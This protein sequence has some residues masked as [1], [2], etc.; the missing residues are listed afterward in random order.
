MSIK[1]FRDGEFNSATVEFLTSHGGVSA[2]TRMLIDKD[3]NV[4]IGSLAGILKGTAGVVSGGATHAELASID[5]NQHI[6]HTTVSISAGTGMSGGG[7]IAANRTLTCTITQYTDALARTACIASSI[8]DGDLTHSPDGN[9]VFDALALK[10]PIAS[11]TFTGTVTMPASIV[12]PDGGTIGQAAGPLIAF[13]D[14]LNYL[15]ITG[16]DVGIGTITPGAKLD[17]AGSGNI[18]IGVDYAGSNYFY[19]AFTTAHSVS[20]VP[21]QLF[22]GMADGAWAGMSIKDFR[23][24]EFNSATVEFLTSHGGVSAGTR[25]LI[26][27]DGN[28][29]INVTPLAQLHI[30]QSSTTAAIP[31]LT[32]DQGDVSEEA[33]RIIG[34]A[35]D[36]VLTQTLVA[37]ADVTTFTPAGYLK[38]YISD[39]GNQ[40]TDGP[41]YVQ[42]GT[43][44]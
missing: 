20:N 32:L 37:S 1:D 27:K 3:G 19:K 38:V 7:T 29:G 5:S 6:D 21:S 35:T 43:I 10:S 17:I 31:V 4:T 18:K 34:T 13:D 30:D 14:T 9:S 16:C 36:N 39:D 28:V 12:I 24:G 26:D 42:F 23:D 41:Y 33:I 2:G 40:V 22:V 44:A 15:E 11:P 8:S 25:M